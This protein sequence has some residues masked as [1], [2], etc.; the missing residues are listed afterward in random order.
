MPGHFVHFLFSPA[1]TIH[2]DPLIFPDACVSNAEGA[3]NLLF[4]ST[5]SHTLLEYTVY[6]SYSDYAMGPF[7]RRWQRLGSVERYYGLT[8][9]QYN[10]EVAGL[11]HLEGH[12][13]A[14]FSGGVALYSR[15]S[16]QL[17]P[18]LFNHYRLS[19]GDPIEFWNAWKVEYAGPVE[20][21]EW[22]A[23]RARL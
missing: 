18:H 3:G 22:V 19:I 13:F 9:A 23:S 12:C 6:H 10:E 4:I 1:Y 16:A 7:F 2:D 8:A 21:P 15:P 20:R 11:T 14:S 17:P 5:P